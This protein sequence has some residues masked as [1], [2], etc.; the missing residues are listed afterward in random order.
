MSTMGNGGFSLLKLSL[1]KN[2]K[3]PEIFSI[4]LEEKKH[5]L[6][7][8]IWLKDRRIAIFRINGTVRVRREEA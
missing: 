3:K 5:Y 7:T 6:I 8:L 1:G 4:P 2:N